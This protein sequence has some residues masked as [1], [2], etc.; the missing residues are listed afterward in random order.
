MTIDHHIFGATVSGP[1]GSCAARTEA[2]HLY[3][4]SLLC[5]ACCPHCKPGEHVA[6]ELMAVAGKG[7]QGDLW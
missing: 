1:C 7:E 6:P 3:N 2:M 5:A 4:G